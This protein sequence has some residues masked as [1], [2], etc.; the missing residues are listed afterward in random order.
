MRIAMVAGL[1]A[2]VHFLAVH[3][4]MYAI[5]WHVGA[6]DARRR[7]TRL[8]ATVL[9]ASA[10]ASAGGAAIGRFVGAQQ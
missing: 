5:G 9:S 2:L 7:A 8:V 1:A 3:R 4:L 10:A 6:S